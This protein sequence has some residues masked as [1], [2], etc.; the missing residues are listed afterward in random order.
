MCQKRVSD[1]KRKGKNCW[2][3]R[4]SAGPGFTEV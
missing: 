1:W 3:E 2:L 4:K